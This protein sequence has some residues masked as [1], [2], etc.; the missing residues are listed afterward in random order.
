ML[1]SS[2]SFKTAILFYLIF[3]LSLSLSIPPSLWFLI[4][5]GDLEK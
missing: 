3:T 2:I 1:S 4:N 5:Q